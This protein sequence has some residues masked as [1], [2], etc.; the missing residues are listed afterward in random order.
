MTSNHKDIQLVPIFT[1]NLNYTNKMITTI[2]MKG[3]HAYRKTNTRIRQC[4]AMLHSKTDNLQYIN[5]ALQKTWALYTCE[6]FA[7]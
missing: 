2:P 6:V 5:S 4:A 1:R 7:P 3:V